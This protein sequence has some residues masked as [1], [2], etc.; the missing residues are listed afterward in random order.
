VKE[1]KLTDDILV[2]VNDISKPEASLEALSEQNL[3]EF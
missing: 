2:T 1:V 3:I